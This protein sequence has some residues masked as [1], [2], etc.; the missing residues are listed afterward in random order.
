MRIP[1]SLGVL[2]LLCARVVAQDPPEPDRIVLTNGDQLSGTV[3][4]M[5]DGNVTLESPLLGEVTVPLSAIA[6]LRTAGTVVLLTTDG[7]TLQ[8]QIIGMRD[9]ELLLAGPEVPAAPSLPVARLD[10]INP[11]EAPA[12]AWTGAF[13]FGG[14]VSTGNTEIRG[15]ALSL[16]A[17][18]RSEIDRMTFQGSWN[19]QEDKQ[20]GAWNLTQR[21]I[22]GGMQ[23]DYFLGDESSYLLGAAAAESDTFQDIQLR[24]TAGAGY[25]YQWVEREDLSFNTEVALNY[26]SQEFRTATPTESYMALRLAE[27]L[28]WEMATGFRLLHAFSY[29]PS[30]ESIDDY[31]LRSD[32]RLRFTMT[33][34]LFTQIQ[35]VLEYNST[36][37]PGFKN[38][39]NRY[40][41]SVG[42]SF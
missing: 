32:A 9:G 37:S 40:F 12:P 39:D 42:W 15:A 30:L 20:G 29:L 36:P 41:L 13:N 14:T 8:R 31:F 2:F 18:R 22:G 28:D 34:N 16:D 19:Y 4:A 1:V 38:A 17:K 7:E 23:Y 33:E 25:G 6:D 21:R 5:A 24:F 35:W 11:P 3:K 26:F 10:Q 27:N